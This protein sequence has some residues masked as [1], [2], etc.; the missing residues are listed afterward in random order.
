ML[1]LH[2]PKLIYQHLGF[3]F[4]KRFPLYNFQW[5][6]IYALPRNANINAYLRSL[7]YKVLNNAL[8]RN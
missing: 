7:Q 2:H 1:S 3:Y 6:D 8:Y 5:K 4:E